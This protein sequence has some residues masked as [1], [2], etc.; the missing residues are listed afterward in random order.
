MFV[1]QALLQFVHHSFARSVNYVELSAD[2]A[3][4]ALCALLF[5][6]ALMSIVHNH[7]QTAQQQAS[8]CNTTTATTTAAAG[9][10]GMNVL[11]QGLVAALLVA[12]VTP[13]ASEGNNVSLLCIILC[14]QK[15]HSSLIITLPSIQ[16]IVPYH[17]WHY[18]SSASCPGGCPTLL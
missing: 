10:W 15:I 1:K 17:I 4:Q 6:L 8:A 7:Q 14:P 3:L 9:T 11:K 18:H 2:P 12:D 5:T 13:V 16:P